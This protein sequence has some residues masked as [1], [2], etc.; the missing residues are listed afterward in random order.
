M[1]MKSPK[2][3]SAL[4][5]RVDHQVKSN[6]R[7]ACKE[8]GTDESTVLRAL[9]TATV[10]LPAPARDALIRHLLSR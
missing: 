5:A 6:F 7:N 9:A 10:A 8:L 4:F 1:T 3:D 2:K